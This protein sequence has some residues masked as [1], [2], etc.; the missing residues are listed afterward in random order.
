MKFIVLLSSLLA[1]VQAN[2]I[3]APTAGTLL[4]AGDDV[5]VQLNVGINN[6]SAAEIEEVS[7]VI[8]IAPCPSDCPAPFEDLGEILF[9]GKY[10]SQGVI[11]NT[12]NGFQNL[13]IS[14]PCDISGQASIQVQH[15]YL[16]TSPQHG[17]SNIEYF[18]VSIQIIPEPSLNIHPNGDNTKCVGILGGTYANG[19][20][21]DIYD[22]N[23]SDSQE[24]QWDGG[25]LTSINSTDESQWCLDAGDES[26]WADGVQMKIWECFSDLP[27]QT[28]IPDISSGNIQLTTANFCLDLTNGATTNQ[29]ILQIWTCGSANPN[30]NWTITTA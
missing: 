25:A 19:T 15:N 20:P 2:S 3:I 1:T 21:V 14:V 10:E 23:A 16:I 24:W 5:T 8:G 28:W 30:Q 26:Q 9:N 11:P 13:T 4:Q 7:L 18:N 6:S 17:Q 29:N 22:C 27:Q 12:L